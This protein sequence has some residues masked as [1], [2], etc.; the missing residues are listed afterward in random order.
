MDADMLQGEVA[1][2]ELDIDE[3]LDFDKFS[4]EPGDLPDIIECI[5][6]SE[7]IRREYVSKTVALSKKDNNYKLDDSTGRKENLAA[8]LK[9]MRTQKKDIM[10]KIKD[11]EDK[12]W[13]RRNCGKQSCND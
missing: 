2:L 7:K 5:E 8:K 6:K 9:E 3:I 4:D 11:E 10:K 1:A 13:E 12:R